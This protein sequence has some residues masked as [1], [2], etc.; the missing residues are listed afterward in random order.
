MSCCNGN[1]TSCEKQ[2]NTA[3]CLRWGIDGCY[4]RAR[5]EDG[6]E[7]DPINLCEWLDK[8]ETCT[9]FRLIVDSTDG[10]YM[11]YTNE[12]DEVAKVYISDFMGLGTLENI[13]N[14]YN[15][16]QAAN[17]ALL[18]YDPSCGDPKDHKYQ[19]WAPYSI[20][21]AGELPMEADENGYFKILTK[22]QCGLIKE[23]KLL[24]TTTTYEYALR[25]SWPDD[26]DWPFTPG[27][28]TEVIDTQ[29]DTKIPIF[30]ATD[31]EVTIQYGYG[32]QRHVYSC[33]RNFQS[34]VVP[35]SSNDPNPSVQ[36]QYSKSIVVQGVNMV[37]WGSAE[38]QVSR[39]F[40]V[41]KGQRLYLIHK[42]T[43]RD[44]AG[45]IKGADDTGASSRLHAL[46]I[47]VSA[48]K[49]VRL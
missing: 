32:I 20:P 22:N 47:F 17:G 9:E 37:P 7:L 31:L 28:F 42:V 19:K 46:H 38:Y 2:C 41:P 18:V 48:T 36:D 4:L 15:E 44:E 25:D 14:V 5:C 49:G 6:S 26:P 39:T 35:S 27:S 43:C 29:L 11:Q 45:N 40:I 8:H 13:G 23:E 3:K 12:C 33:A 21:D 30:G 1:N 34:L 24:A 10:G 16:E